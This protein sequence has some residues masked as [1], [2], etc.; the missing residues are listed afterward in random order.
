[1]DL[2]FDYSEYYDRIAEELPNNSRLVEVGSGDGISGLYLAKK[3]YKLNKGFKLYMVDSMAYGSYLQMKEIYENVIKS[4]LGEM[5]E[6]IPLDSLKASCKFNGGSLD[7]VFIDSSHEYELT[8][9]EI[10]LWY[11]K[12]KDGGLLCGHDFFSNENP[13]VGQAVKELLPEEITRQPIITYDEEKKVLL[14]EFQPEKLLHTEQTKNGN[15]IWSV[16]K[17]FYFKP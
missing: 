8:R 3:L 4:G 12:L 2:M 9:A 1:M 13:G 15:G 14:D 7:M 16:R 10:I 17:L 6:V 5:I 11:D